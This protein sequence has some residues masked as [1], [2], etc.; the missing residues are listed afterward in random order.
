MN[1]E[2]TKLKTKTV[3][4]G[5]LVEFLDIGEIIQHKKRFGHLFF[6][7]FEDNQ[8]IRGNHY[9][10]LQHEYYIVLEG[11]VK[12][13]LVDI[14]SKKR[15]EVTLSAVNNQFKRLRIGPRIAHATYS[16]TP[17]A[18]MLGYYS[19]PF[20]PDKVDTVPYVIIKQ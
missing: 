18:T 7:S 14:D 13:V 8:T 9:H 17:K 6:V 3:K 12:V 5:S 2:L 19:R 15:K 16:L 11:K 1:C 10:K 20:N 4:K